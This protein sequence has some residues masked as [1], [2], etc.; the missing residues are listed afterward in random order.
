MDEFS[1][2]SH[3]VAAAVGAGGALWYVRRVSGWVTAFEHTVAQD[4]A[5]LKNAVFGSGRPIA[6]PPP[7]MPPTASMPPA[8]N[9]ATVPAALS[10]SGGVA[11]G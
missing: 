8:A 3:A 7:P 11:G 1:V 4:I 9:P 2:L 10:G 6:A 5:S